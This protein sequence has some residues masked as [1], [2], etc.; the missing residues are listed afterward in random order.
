MEIE[1]E[2]AI[3]SPSAV[4][5]LM[6][7]PGQRR[8]KS[9]GFDKQSATVKQQQKKA[10]FFLYTYY[11]TTLTFM[12]VRWIIFLGK[13]SRPVQCPLPRWKLSA[14]WCDTFPCAPLS[15]FLFFF[16]LLL[17]G[18]SENRNNTVHQAAKAGENSPSPP[19]FFPHWKGKFLPLFNQRRGKRG[20]G[21]LSRG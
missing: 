8:A 10:R 12:E 5:G 18:K 11:F 7:A 16:L 4:G 9:I 14:A 3:V 17:R 2:R 21:R 15:L 6:L 1:E 20:G 19:F 13:A